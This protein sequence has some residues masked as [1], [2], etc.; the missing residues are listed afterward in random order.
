MKKRV[1]MFVPLLLL[2]ITIKNSI[3]HP[4]TYWGTETYI[5]NSTFINLENSVL[6]EHHNT[7][8]VH[9]A[10]E[11]KLL[12]SKFENEIQL[13]V[14]KYQGIVIAG[15]LL[16]VYDNVVHTQYMAANDKAR[17]I[18]GLDLLMK[19]VIDIFAQDKTYFDFGISTEENGK[20][21][22]NGLISQKEGFGG[23]TA[24]YQTWEITY[25]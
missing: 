20:I 22:N 16:F 1:V 12:N 17:E 4:K 8:A 5:Y 14:A 11:L 15:T 10:D 23:R 24:I 21:L 3:I 2:L 25:E 6:A 13:W 18:G 9:T 19:T 7:K